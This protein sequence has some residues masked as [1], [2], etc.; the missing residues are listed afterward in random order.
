MSSN[1]QIRHFFKNQTIFITGGSGFLGKV[2]LEKL[3]RECEE[4]KKIYVLMRSKKNKT[5]TQRFIRATRDLLELAKKMTNLK[6]F[7]F[8][9]TAYSN[10]VHAD[11]KEQFY[12]PPMKAKQLLQLV[13]ALDDDTLKAITPQLLKTWPNTYVFGKSIAE[14]LINTIGKDLPITVVRPA[15]I[16]SSISEPRIGWHDNFYGIIGVCMGTSLGIIRVINL[17]KN[18]I[19]P[20]VPVDYVSNCVLAAAWQRGTC[21][22]TTIYNFVG[23]KNNQITWGRFIKNSEANYL[24]CALRKAVWHFSLTTVENKVCYKICTFFLHTVPA[25]IADFVLVCLGK[26]ALY[27]VVKNYGRLDRLLSAVLYFCTGSWNFEDHNVME[28]WNAMADEDK[29][30]F[31]FN[32]ERVDYDI[33]IRNSVIGTRLYLFKETRENSV[34]M[35]YSLEQNT[36]II[37]SYYR[38]GVLNENVFTCIH[39]VLCESLKT[40]IRRIVARFN[41]TGSVSKGKPTRPQVSEDVEDLR[42]RMEESPKKSLSKLSLQSGEL[43]PADFPRRV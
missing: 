29:T 13:D 4:I 42:T 10:C 15:I 8:V 33:Y 16:I 7:V 23:H 35:G 30:L 18:G 39:R 12:E 32:M 38:N 41:D 1:S 26:P 34:R 14:D 43:Q 3:L 2:L 21:D 5:P 31:C 6:V 37:M 28:L 36:F 11:I 9:S 40:P 22:V 27:W 20:L 24:E 17:K 25:Y 19:A